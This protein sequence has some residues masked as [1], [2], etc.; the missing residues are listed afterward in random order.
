LASKRACDFLGYAEICT[1][2]DLER[3]YEFFTEGQNDPFRRKYTTRNDRMD[4]ADSEKD[5]SGGV[6]SSGV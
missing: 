1:N 6:I 5:A 4:R 3:E 2:G